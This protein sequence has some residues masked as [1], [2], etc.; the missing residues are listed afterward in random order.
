MES[1][2]KN[3]RQIIQLKRICKDDLNFI[4]NF[5]KKLSI[6]HPELSNF[7][8]MLPNGELTVESYIM[9]K[10][11]IEKNTLTNISLPTLNNQ[12]YIVDSINCD[13]VEKEIDKNEC[14]YNFCSYENPQKYINYD[15]IHEKYVAKF[16]RTIVTGIDFIKV[17][18]KLQH[19][20]KNSLIVHPIIDCK[21][22]CISYKNK[23]IIL[24]CGADKFLYFD[25]R[26]IISLLNI[27]SYTRN[28]EKYDDLSLVDKKL[29]YSTNKFGHCPAQ[30]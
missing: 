7:I 5:A 30:R 2:I 12:T 14:K 28:R 15:E 13:D 18:D 16:N 1:I 23:K 4:E 6:N 27:P 24:Y 3:L 22:I 9:I 19:I 20:M 10:K 25:I 17:C 21:K 26:H 29:T 11:F 8:S